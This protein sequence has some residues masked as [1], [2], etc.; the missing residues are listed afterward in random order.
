MQRVT[1]LCNSQ[2]KFEKAGFEINTALILYL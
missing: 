1:G 2:K